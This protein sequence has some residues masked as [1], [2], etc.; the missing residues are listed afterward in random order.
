MAS[1]APAWF[2]TPFDD[3]H[4]AHALAVTT[5]N[6]LVIVDRPAPVGVTIL[7]LATSKVR[8]VL[9]GG[10]EGRSIAVTTDGSQA[11]LSELGDFHVTRIDLENDVPPDVVPGTAGKPIFGLTV[12]PDGS[13]LVA[14][15]LDLD[16]HENVLAIIPLRAGGAERTFRL[17]GQQMPYT[18]ALTPDGKRAI[19]GIGGM[20]HFDLAT[21]AYTKIPQGGGDSIAIA[22]DGFT[23]WV[24]AYT[25]GVIELDLAT[26]TRGRAIPF[27]A[28]T[29]ICSLAVSPDGKRAVV[30]AF[31]E[32]GVLD[33]VAGKVETTYPIASRC[34]AISADGK[35]AYVSIIGSPHGQVVALKLP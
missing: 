2:A 28:A 32:I 9:T 3:V 19:V 33:L 4:I 12:T 15:Y 20:L 13:A 34:P 10:R 1:N 6:K 16:L 31:K 21:G 22:G 26:N 25:A 29:D 18:L 23:G 8:K 35:R 24:S 17:G 14:P 30:A 5:T 11:Y 27:T 7:D